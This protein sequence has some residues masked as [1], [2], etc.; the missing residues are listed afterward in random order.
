LG[1]CL[2]SIKKKIQ[3]EGRK[4]WKLKIYFLANKKLYIYALWKTRLKLKVEGEE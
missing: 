2:F 4:I 3:V 1:I